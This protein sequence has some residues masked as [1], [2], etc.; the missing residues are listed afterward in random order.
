MVYHPIGVA[1][2]CLGV[3]VFVGCGPQQPDAVQDLGILIP[4]GSSQTY[5]SS[6]EPAADSVSTGVFV[7]SSTPY[8]PFDASGFH[9]AF[10]PGAFSGDGGSSGDGDGS[11]SSFAALTVP[12]GVHYAGGVSGTDHQIL[13]GGYPELHL[14]KQSRALIGTDEGHGVVGMSVPGFAGLSDF[15]I[16]VTPVGV[17]SEY[18]GTS[19]GPLIMDY[20]YEVTPR[21]WAENASNF[22]GEFEIAVTA[23]TG[24]FI[25][26]G[27]ATHTVDGVWIDDQIRYSAATA[28]DCDL[29]R[30]ENSLL[31]VAHPTFE[32]AGRLSREEP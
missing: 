23:V 1:A 14:P 2:S 24:G 12:G 17:T 9:A 15:S 5:S 6:D 10:P 22:H 19:A 4:A 20:T 11:D 3:A 16:D 32:Y 29:A 13:E 31:F 27:S 8:G 18:T 21:F 28:Y 30:P 25:I 7:D 26:S